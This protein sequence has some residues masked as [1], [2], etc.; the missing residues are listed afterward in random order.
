MLWVMVL[1]RA[2]QACAADERCATDADSDGIG[3][4]EDCDDHD[5]RRSP[6]SEE[7]CNGIDDDCD[8]VIDAGALDAPRWFPD[9]DG[10]GYGQD[11]D[12]TRACAPP[13]DQVAQH[14]DCLDTRATVHPGA[15]ETC[16]GVDDDCD[17]LVD[18]DA[19]DG[20]WWYVDADADGYGDD[21]TGTWACESPAGR[22]ASMDGDCDDGDPRAYPGAPEACGRDDDCDGHP[23]GCPYIGELAASDIFGVR[24]DFPGRDRWEYTWELPNGVDA[25]ADGYNDLVAAGPLSQAVG[26]EETGLALIFAGEA[27][28]S[29]PPLVVGPEVARAEF[30][31]EPWWNLGEASIWADNDGAPMLALLS[32]ATE[33]GDTH[34]HLRLIWGPWFTGPLE[35]VT[36]DL[37]ARASRSVTT[38]R[39]HATGPSSVAVAAGGAVYLIQGPF[40]AKSD[41]DDAATV[42]TGLENPLGSFLSAGDLDGDGLDE[43]ATFA[44]LETCGGIPYAGHIT[45]NY[46]PLPA[47]EADLADADRTICGADK[48]YAGYAPARLGDLN[49]DGY[50]E[51]GYGAPGWPRVDLPHAGQFAAFFGP[52]LDGHSTTAAADLKVN[53]TLSRVGFGDVPAVSP[54]LDGDGNPDLV[55]ANRFG[56]VEGTRGYGAVRIFYGP[57]DAGTYTD[58]ESDAAISGTAQNMLLGISI[59]DLGDVNADGFDDLGVTAAGEIE[60]RGQIYIFFGG[61]PS[62]GDGCAARGRRAAAAGGRPVA[63]GAGGLRRDAHRQ[64]HRHAGSRALQAAHGHRLPHARLELA[65]DEAHALPALGGAAQHPVP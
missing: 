46:A 61:N 43:I 63:R 65:A 36:L 19:V 12:G 33:Y 21:T 8:G 16:N 49:G 28:A 40:D 37:P 10:D 53:G 35:T 39:F 18:D 59:A 15:P 58:N 26:E 48:E 11:I 51:L 4:C 42:M 38:G 6:A 9:V 5:A 2:L 60:N 14:G 25:D 57:I 23:R 56:E 31:G 13:V 41:I 50:A 54:D 52:V 45:I 44:P 7:S 30:D 64:R 20:S 22:G 3:A 17:G 62:I 55:V 27:L 29:D 1:L 47:G 24:I 34:D 32:D